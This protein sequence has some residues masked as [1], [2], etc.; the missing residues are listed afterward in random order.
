MI[1]ILQQKN[2]IIKSRRK[3]NRGLKQEK[4]NL[5]GCMSKDDQFV[6][7]EELAVSTMLEVQALIRISENKGL[8]MQDE[9]LAEVEVL[10][11]EME[12]KIRKMGRENL[13]FL[14]LIALSKHSPVMFILIA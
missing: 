1:S 11:K 2:F 5:R 7:W 4:L 10:K 9:I 6:S 13:A 8:I 3:K 14:F 12:Q